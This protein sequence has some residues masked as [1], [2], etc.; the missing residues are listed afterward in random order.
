MIDIT[1][2]W[3]GSKTLSRITGRNFMRIIIEWHSMM[4]IGADFLLKGNDY[5]RI[6]IAVN[7]SYRRISNRN[8]SEPVWLSGNHREQ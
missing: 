5:I 2:N 3:R 4:G 6:P 7:I 1:D 8:I